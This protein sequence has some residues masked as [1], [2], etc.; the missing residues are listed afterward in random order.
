M[1]K[2]WHEKF[3]Y[4]LACKRTDKP[5]KAWGLC[6]NC[7]VKWRANN[8]FSKTKEG[9][10]KRSIVRR[11]HYRKHREKITKYW[12]DNFG[13]TSSP[14]RAEYERNR[15]HLWYLKKKAEKQKQAE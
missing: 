5:Y 2:H 14:E 11:R 13:P 10:K 9:K 4:C 3:D 8:K 12:R 7:Y 1:K 6:I 15:K